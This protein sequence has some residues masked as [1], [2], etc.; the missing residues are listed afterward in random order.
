M[1]EFLN[2]ANPDHLP[3]S[4]RDWAVD[5]A[6][7]AYG[8]LFVATALHVQASDYERFARLLGTHSIINLLAPAR[9]GELIEEAVA[10][11]VEQ[12]A[13]APD[14]TLRDPVEL[15]AVCAATGLTGPR[16]G[17]LCLSRKLHCP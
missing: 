6:H 14:G 8:E 10:V 9:R 1:I 15:R 11:A 3:A 4:T 5:F 16:R 17:T 12:G 2:T 7:P 13:F